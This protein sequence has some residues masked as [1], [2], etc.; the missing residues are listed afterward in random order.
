[1]SFIN[2][3]SILKTLSERIAQLPVCYVLLIQ[4]LIS[5]T[6]PR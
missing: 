5:L 6:E 3:Y 4:L 1:M 2:I